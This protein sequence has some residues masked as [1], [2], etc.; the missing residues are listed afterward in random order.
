V[1]RIVG[2]GGDQR[3]DHDAHDQPGGKCAL[4]RDL[5]ADGLASGTHPGSDRQRCEEAVD[6]GRDAGKDFEQRFRDG[7][8]T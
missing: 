6:D 5:E 3:D 1:N 7:T 4:R 8:N 2:Q